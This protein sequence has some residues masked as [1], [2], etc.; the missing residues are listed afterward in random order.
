MMLGPM[1][2]AGRERQQQ[3][4]REAEQARLVR[5]ASPRR[6]A[7]RARASLLVAGL[8]I[9]LGYAGGLLRARYR[10]GDVR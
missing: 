2:D 7:P 5:A 4:L 8:S 6:S 3:R 1:W 10:R 9:F